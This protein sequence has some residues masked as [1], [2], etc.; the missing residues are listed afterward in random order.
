[1]NMFSSS[2]SVASS[3]LGQA[4]TNK[5]MDNER[6]IN[7]EEYSMKD[8]DRNL[9]EWNKWNISIEKLDKI[10]QQ[11]SFSKISFLRDYTIKNV[12]RTYSL[13][14]E[15]ETIQLFLIESI[16]RHK[17]KYA[18][19]HIGLVQVAVKP[20]TREALNTNILLCLRD[21]IHLRFNDSLLGMM[22]TTLHNGP[23]YFNCYNNFALSLSYRNIMDALTLNIK[24]DGII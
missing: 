16:N 18:F 6:I 9:L 1:M 17:E 19:L 13:Y 12:E 8:I 10:Y 21:D 11:T 22:E 14:N 20:L 3:H 4:H 5:N 15:Y 23:I 24:T 2:S 7:F